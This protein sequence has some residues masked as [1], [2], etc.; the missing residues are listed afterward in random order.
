MLSIVSWRGFKQNPVAYKYTD[1]PNGK[2]LFGDS[3][4]IAL[5][6]ILDK[7]STDIV[8]NKLTPRAD[9]QRNESLNSTIGS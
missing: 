6:D 3:L 5:S 8:V 7:Y 4:K 9:S 2:D 1:L